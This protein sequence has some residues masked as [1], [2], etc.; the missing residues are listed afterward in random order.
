MIRV[1]AFERPPGAEVEAVA[2]FSPATLH[3]ALGQTGAVDHAI[4][5]IHRG[6]K[7]PGVALA[8]DCEPGDNLAIHAAVTRGRPGDVLVVDD[9]GNLGFGP[10]GDVLATACMR[11]GTAGLVFGGC[12]RDGAALQAMGFPVF[13]RGLNIQGTG[14][15]RPGVVGTPIVCG[16]VCVDPGDVVDPR[17][18]L[19]EVAERAREREEREA[20]MREKLRSG[21]TTIAL[22]GLAPLLQETA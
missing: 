22:L 18:Q 14:K 17:A 3:E 5:P 16:G 20:A 9:K 8:V 1:D 7:V 10:F 21:A 15:K 2:S 19:K 12:V 11:A 6:M 13:A 4:A